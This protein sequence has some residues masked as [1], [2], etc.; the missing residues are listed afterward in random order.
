[1]SMEGLSPDELAAAQRQVEQYGVRAAEIVKELVIC[2][3]T[4]DHHGGGRLVREMYDEPDLL[5]L[6]IGMLTT[7]VVKVATAPLATPEQIGVELTPPEP[8]QVGTYDQM[9]AAAGEQDLIA[10]AGIAMDAQIRALKGDFMNHLAEHGH[11]PDVGSVMRSYLIA[12]RMMVTVMA[13]EA[14]RRL[15]MQEVHSDG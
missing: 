6:V 12:D 11:F 7:A 8:W 9:A 13:A 5:M 14:I 15:V 1:M 4:K 3:Q 10:F 2:Y